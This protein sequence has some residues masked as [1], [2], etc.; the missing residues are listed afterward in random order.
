[1]LK[2]LISVIIPVYNAQE[3]LAL[4][5]ESVRH[6]TYENFEL[7]LIN[8]GS[9]DDSAQICDAYAKLDDRIRVIHQENK[10]VSAARN[11]G[12]EEARGKYISF[13]DADDSIDPLTFEN[14]LNLIVKH[15]ADMAIW[16]MS[17]DYY[18]NGQRKKSQQRVIDKEICFNTEDIKAYFFDLA[19]QNYLVSIC[20]K[21]IRLEIIKE[22]NLG[23]E[24]EMSILE[25]FKFILDLLEKSQ[26]ICAVPQAFYHYYHDLSR[27]RMKRRPRIDYF[28]NFQILDRR[29]REFSQIFNLEE[30]KNKT[31]IDGMIFRYYLIAVEK[32]Y[33]GS[34]RFSEKYQDMKALMNR[35][36]LEI[37]S[38]RAQVIGL[39]LR[40]VLFLVNKKMFRLLAILFFLNDWLDQI[41]KS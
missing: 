21:M 34:G 23:F 18:Q 33:S 13:I 22:N 30:Q 28:R 35:D 29:L 24:V 2:A 25:D 26:K 36:E 12:L 3:R 10:R 19:N 11:R 27:S 8:D 4:A 5:I 38:K 32:L 37:A 1:M 39:R 14:S 41:K 16:G 20:N 6:Q 40:M 7:I 31:L 15:S 9:T 17:F